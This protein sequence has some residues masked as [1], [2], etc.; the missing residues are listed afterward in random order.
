MTTRSTHLGLKVQHG[1]VPVEDD[2][3]AHFEVP[4]MRSLYFHVLDDQEEVA[5]KVARYDLLAI[6]V[7]DDEHRLL[8]I[9]THDDAIDIITQEHTEDMEKFKSYGHDLDAVEQLLRKSLL[10]W[11]S[12][13]GGI[14]AYHHA[15]GGNNNWPEFK[16]LLGMA[17]WGHPWNEE[18][19]IKLEEPDH[20]LLAAF[21]GK[22]LRLAEEIFQLR[23]PYSREKLRVLLPHWIEHNAEHAAVFRAWAERAGPA[24]DALLA[25]AEFLDQANGPLAEALALLAK[26]PYSYYIHINDNDGKWDWDYFC[27]TKH[28][29]EYVEF[30]YYLKKYGY[31]DYL[32][33][34]TSPTRWDIVGT[35]EAN[36]RISNKIWDLL[37][38]I[39]MHE[40]ER[41]IHQADY[42]ETWKFIETNILGL[43]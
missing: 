2:G 28:F 12:N 30:L 1:V 31:E 27:G 6:P 35:F 42:L 20:P 3:S 38:R 25:A 40:M 33:S 24:R 26:S 13:G 43:K 5:D 29:L 7:V 37:E 17:Y 39:D 36:S 41:L 15:I 16:E 32:T 19:G 8:G 18:V 14:V 9:I 21:G 10:D 22:D 4:A 23:E 34:D 11:V